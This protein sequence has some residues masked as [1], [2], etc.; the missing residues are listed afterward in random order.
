MY[1]IYAGAEQ[2]QGVVLSCFHQ[3]IITLYLVASA[4]TNVTATQRDA[5][6]IEVHWRPPTPLE[7]V[8]GYRIYYTEN[9]S[10]VVDISDAF[11]DN[12]LLADLQNGATYH[13][14]ILSLSQHFPSNKVGALVVTLSELCYDVC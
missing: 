9:I 13:L 1:I 14:Y 12:Y 4:P 8:I 6:S 5:T 10:N 7:H 2:L 11:I 3:Y